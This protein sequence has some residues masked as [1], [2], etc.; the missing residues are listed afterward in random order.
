MCACDLTFI[1]MC[2]VEK[3]SVSRSFCCVHGGVSKP[4]VDARSLDM[5]GYFEAAAATEENT[6]HSVMAAFQDLEYI[7]KTVLR[8]ATILVEEPSSGLVSRDNSLG[9]YR[10]DNDTSPYN[11]ISGPD[12]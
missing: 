5:T 11:C 6:P 8:S 1:V 2:F 9:M 3:A 4:C 10:H 12:S 7:S